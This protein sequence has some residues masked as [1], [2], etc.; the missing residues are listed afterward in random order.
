MSL[1]LKF[2]Q[3]L[4]QRRAERILDAMLEQCR[5]YGEDSELMVL[6]TLAEVASIEEMEFAARYLGMGDDA[7]ETVE[8][9]VEMRQNAKWN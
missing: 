1:L 3:K 5:G 2:W 9:A 8:M 7:L 6:Y 4:K